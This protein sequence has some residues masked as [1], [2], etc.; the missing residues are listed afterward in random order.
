M[1]SQG[2]GR[3][4]IQTIELIVLGQMSMREPITLNYP[5]CL[6][7]PIIYFFQKLVEVVNALGKA[8]HGSL[9]FM[10]EQVCSLHNPYYFLWGK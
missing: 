1:I 5:F 7:H 6:M 10:T 2:I 9:I 8:G 3:E 4:I